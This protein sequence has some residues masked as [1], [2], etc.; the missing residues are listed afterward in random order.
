MG[1]KRSQPEILEYHDRIIYFKS[2]EFNLLNMNNHLVEAIHKIY[3]CEFCI[4]T[5]RDH[6]SVTI[7]SDGMGIYI[8]TYNS[9]TYK[10]ERIIHIDKYE[11]R[12]KLQT[13]EYGKPIRKWPF[14][15]FW[16]KP[17]KE[18]QKLKRLKDTNTP[19]ETM[20]E[21]NFKI[22]DAI[23]VIM[24][25]KQMGRIMT[26][27][28]LNDLV[29]I[30][31]DRDDYMIYIC[32]KFL[33]SFIIQV[34]ERTE[35]GWKLFNTYL[36]LGDLYA[37]TIY[38]MTCS[39]Y[40]IFIDTISKEYGDATLVFKKGTFEEMQ[41]LYGYSP[42]YRDDYYYWRKKVLDI[43]KQVAEMGKMSEDLLSVILSYVA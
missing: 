37:R 11:I 13:V 43:L 2:M 12:T 34:F 4:Y 6:R 17:V 25:G 20:D 24:N 28:N 16:T 15:D 32:F 18:I 5:E 7:G 39:K 38:R 10:M 19:I 30:T 40:H 41:T 8:I 23:E 42:I 22:N 36:R 14:Y 31:Y 3:K 21:I 26:T 35:N 1:Q 9:P 27:N 29:A 33:Q